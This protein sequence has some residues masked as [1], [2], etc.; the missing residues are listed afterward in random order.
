MVVRFRLWNQRVPGSIQHAY[1]RATMYISLVHIKSDVE[2][3]K[4][5]SRV[6]QK[7]GEWELVHI[8][9][10]SSDHDSKLMSAFENIHVLLQAERHYDTAKLISVFSFH[11][12]ILQ[13]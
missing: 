1:Q 4:S 13:T 11:R 3:Q 6:V 8:S 12:T 2:N 7:S 10:S 9:S 5:P